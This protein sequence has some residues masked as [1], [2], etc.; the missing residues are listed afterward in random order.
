MEKLQHIA[1]VVPNIGEALAWYRSRFDVKIA[2]ADDSWA[3]LQFENVALA[4]VLPGHHPPHIAVERADAESY[5]PLTP[6]RDGTASVYVEDPWG[7]AIEI[8][9]PERR[10]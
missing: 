5:G 8:M 4:F 1:L 3:L 9:K 2:Y 6:H 10:G 7:N